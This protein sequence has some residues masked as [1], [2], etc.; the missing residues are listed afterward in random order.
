[1]S[2]IINEKETTLIVKLLKK[3]I[4]KNTLTKEELFI[5]H[6]Q[7]EDIKHLVDK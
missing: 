1:M 7:Y 2:I 4:K 6:E 3:A 5:E